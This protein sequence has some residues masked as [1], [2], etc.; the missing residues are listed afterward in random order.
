MSSRPDQQYLPIASSLEQIISNLAHIPVYAVVTYFWLRAFMGSPKMATYLIIIGVL[1]FSVSDEIHQS[2]IPGR[3]PSISDI[4]LDLIGMLIGM[5]VLKL[6][7]KQ[8]VQQD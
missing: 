1:L 4:G 8:R 3:T 7:K 5:T 6:T 2:F